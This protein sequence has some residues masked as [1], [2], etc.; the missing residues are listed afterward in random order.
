M[1]LFTF[2]GFG[3]YDQYHA[4]VFTLIN[5]HDEITLWYDVLF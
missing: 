3:Y 4:S 5:E 1:S 2:L